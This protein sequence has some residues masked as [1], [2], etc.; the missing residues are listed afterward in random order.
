MF[1]G[2]AVLFA[3][4][5]IGS[6]IS[7]PDINNFT[8]VLSKELEFRIDDCKTGFVGRVFV[9]QNPNDPNEFVRMYYRQVAIV[10]ER[11]CEKNISEADSS[12]RNLFNLNYHRKKELEILSRVQKATDVFAYVQWK[13]VRDSRTGHDI[14]IELFQ[15][16]L[17]DPSG[18][19]VYHTQPA[20][21]KSA[22][23][24]SVFSEPSKVNS[25]KRINVGIRFTLGDTV[26]IV[27]VDQDDILVAV[28]SKEIASEHK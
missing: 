20:G 25:K 2:L 18:V 14:Q 4:E 15:I 12:N 11:A 27:R 6:G 22:L 21:T 24:L 16:G 28:N 5:I 10:S 7:P 1:L 19:W 9:Y 8:P 26:H 17:L 13:I 23:E 3:T